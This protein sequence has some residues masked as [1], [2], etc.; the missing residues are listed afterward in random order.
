MRLSTVNA[1]KTSTSESGNYPLNPRLINLASGVDW[2]NT[3]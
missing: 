3:W 1:S 2:F